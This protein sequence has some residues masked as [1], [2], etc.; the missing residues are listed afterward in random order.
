MPQLFADLI[1]CGVPMLIERLEI[2][3][4]TCQTL[5]ANF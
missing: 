5:S 2:L 1:C 3:E 4:D